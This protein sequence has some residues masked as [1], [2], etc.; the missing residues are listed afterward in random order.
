MTRP[1]DQPQVVYVIGHPDD[2]TGPGISPTGHRSAPASGPV[3]GSAQ[4]SAAFP[5][6]AHAQILS[7]ATQA[8]V[9]DPTRVQREFPDR[10][11]A[12]IRSNF[13]NLNHV[14]QVFGVSE[15]A[16]RKW[17]N[18]ESGANGGYVAIA[19]AEHPV[20]AQRMLFAAE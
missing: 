18:G 19:M 14:Q 8:P 7:H 10:W 1:S 15:R 4:R 5:H 13:R 3:N 2:G 11:R 16:A 17:W 12:Y 6:G 20:A 9:Y